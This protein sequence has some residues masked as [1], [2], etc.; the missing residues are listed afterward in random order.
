MEQFVPPVEVEIFIHVEIK[1]TFD[2]KLAKLH[3]FKL[4]LTCLTQL[5]AVGSVGGKDTV[6]VASWGIVLYV[7]RSGHRI[8]V[9]VT[10][11]TAGL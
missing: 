11:T 6:G 3:K 1:R 9:I 2:W 10:V 7:P 5:V 8:N 4:D